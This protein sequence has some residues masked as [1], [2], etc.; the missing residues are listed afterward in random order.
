MA[1]GRSRILRQHVPYP[2]HITQPF[3]L[4]AA[5]PDLATLYLQ[6]A[7]GGLYSGD[8]LDLSLHTREGS[9]LAI[10][11]QSAT[12]VHD[13]RGVPA[14]QRVHLS[15][16]NNSVMIYT[17]DPL[18]LFPGAALRSSLEV[19]LAPG[20]IALCQEG[21]ACHDPG[22][23]GGAFDRLESDII[24]R[25][26]DGRIYAADRSR[27][28]GHSLGTT[29]SPLG[30][31]RA[32]GSFLVLGATLPDQAALRAGIDRIGCFSGIA[33]LPNEIG[34]AIRLLAPDGGRLS[35]GLALAFDAC[36][37]AALGIRPAVR[38]K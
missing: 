26:P 8:H 28:S 21:F 20:A 30:P 2:F 25:A 19:T 36:F 16:T 1:G 7:S 27:I 18:V 6:S 33:D 34:I 12:L 5:R 24:L 37:H 35:R 14:V 29:A 32:S 15:L 9:A 31:F 22:G 11:T 38:R 3:Y 13:C 10:T 17:P 4:D 23:D